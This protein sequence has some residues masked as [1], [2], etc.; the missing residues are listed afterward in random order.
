M[1]TPLE[2]ALNFLAKRNPFDNLRQSQYVAL[3]MEYQEKKG[4]DAIIALAGFYVFAVTK[5]PPEKRREAIL[6]TFSHDLNGRDDKWML[7]RSTNYKDV[8]MDEFYPDKK[9]KESEILLTPEEKK[10]LSVENFEKFFGHKG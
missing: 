9:S 4:D 8:F 1:N 3:L 2:H 6:T 7:P 5:L 10:M